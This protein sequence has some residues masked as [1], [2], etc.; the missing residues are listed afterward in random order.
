MPRRDK[1][2]SVKSRRRKPAAPKRG[3][4]TETA[5]PRSPSAAGQESSIARLER[6]LNE[7]LERETAASEILKIVSSSQSS[8]QPAL[9]AVAANAARLCGALSATIYLRDNNSIIVHA[10]SGPLSGTPMGGRRDVRIDSIAGR[11][12]TESRILHLTD[13]SNSNE[14]PESREIARRFSHGSTLAVPL[15]RDGTAVGAILIRRAEVRAYGEREIALVQNFAA[16]AVLRI[17]NARLLNELRQ[18]TSDLTEALEQQTAS[19]EVLG[20]ISASPGELEPVFQTILQNATRLCEAQNTFIFLRDGEV[21]RVVARHGFSPE[22][23]KF[24]EEHPIPIDRGSAVGRTAIESR[25]VHIPDVLGDA[26]YSRRGPQEVGGY[27]AVLG[28]PLLRDGCSV[29]VLFLTRTAPHPFTAQHI[30]LVQTFAD[31]AVI[32]MENARLLGELRERTGQLEAQSQE[33]I[34][35][36]RELEK[37][38]TDQVGE[39]ERMSRLRRFL[40]PQVADLIVASGTEKQLESHRREITALFCDLRGF[41][42]F[43]ESSDPEDVMI[44]LRDYHAAIGKIIIKHSG[45]LERYAGDGVM[46]V[47]NDPVPVENPAMHA[48]LMALEMRKT[49]GLLTDK[50]ARLGHDLGF[51]I[52]IAHGFATLG[53]IGFEGR[54]DYAAIGTVTNVAS[55]LCDEAKPGQI[56]IS[57]RVLIAVEDAVTAES[58]GEFMLKGI[59]RPM[60]AHN[61]LAA[62]TAHQAQPE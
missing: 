41:T 42:G 40:P 58:V 9:D 19:A 32:A 59:R 38:V 24:T 1:E 35:L 21:C 12:I 8:V 29:G 26:E 39:I 5:R 61:V 49:I 46:V 28:A 50:W 30:G 34:R 6:D 7:A 45:T 31:Q 53:A 20:V 15:L 62:K 2:G 13:P 14:Y 48:V 27:R 54:F 60:A 56:L 18:R 36:N 44:L 33:V 16:Q 23:L 55:R 11:A 10:Q 47:F 25:I 52:G 51:G 17:E 43:S 37:R 3:R 22:F 4:G 57:P